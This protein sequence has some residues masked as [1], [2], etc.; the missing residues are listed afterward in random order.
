ML[1][2]ALWL[3]TAGEGIPT[4]EY[5]ALGARVAKLRRDLRQWEDAVQLAQ[6]E[7]ATEEQLAEKIL[8]ELAKE[9]AQSINDLSLYPAS[10]TAERLRSAT[11]K[12]RSAQE[13]NYST[14]AGR[15]VDVAQ[16]LVEEEK[17]AVRS[18]VAKE[19]RRQKHISQ[20]EIEQA[21]FDRRVIETVSSHAHY[22]MA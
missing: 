10:P 15:K 3:S 12:G 22:V 5:Q 13:L 8:A 4:S 1:V 21:K 20:L 9:T 18:Y 6:S 16:L 2:C 17:K 7:L 14:L 19:A 11:F